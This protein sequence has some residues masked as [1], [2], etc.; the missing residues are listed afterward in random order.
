MLDEAFL[1][2]KLTPEIIAAYR[3]WCAAKL[4]ESEKKR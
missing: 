2:G 1:P 4:A 3:R